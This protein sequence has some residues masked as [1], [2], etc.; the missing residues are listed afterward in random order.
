[1]LLR[2]GPIGAQH[3][4][5]FGGQLTQA[6]ATERHAT[7]GWSF[8]RQRNDQRAGG[9]RKH[10]GAAR[11]RSIQQSVTASGSKAGAPALHRGAA[12]PLLLRQP[13]GAESSGAAENDTRSACQTLRCGG[14]PCP[15]R[16]ASLLGRR[17]GNQRSRSDH[18]EPPSA[19]LLHGLGGGPEA[20][21]A[22]CV[23][24]R[25]LP[26]WQAWLLPAADKTC[27][28]CRPL[29]QTYRSCSTSVTQHAV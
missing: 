26:H 3:G 20:S 5:D 2:E 13:A 28:G 22:D 4:G 15:R 18:A 1:M 21:T 24:E 11:A 27:R 10:D 25:L 19:R 6:I 9:W 17:Q 29:S 7:F 14:S 16:Q 23:I 12:H 8:A